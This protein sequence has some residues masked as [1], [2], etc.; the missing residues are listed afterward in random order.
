MRLCLAS[1]ND[2]PMKFF[3]ITNDPEVAAFA[4]TRGVDRIFVDLEMLGKQERQGHLDTVI[5]RHSLADVALVR[6]VVP[7]GGLLV[8]VN[9]IHQHSQAEI[10]AVIDAG[11]DV[12]ML[13]MFR[14]RSE[15]EIFCRAVAGR[16]K[17]SLLVETVAAVESLR[18][19]LRVPG[20]DEVHIGLNDLHL[21]L[22]LRFMFELVAD[23]TVDRMTVV[24][25]GE[26]IPFGIGGLAR[27]GEGLLPAELL[28]AEHARLGSTA[29]I[30]SRTFHRQARSVADIQQQMDFAGEVGKLRSAYA[31]HGKAT[32]AELQ[33][34]HQELQARVSRIVAAM[35]PRLPPMGAVRA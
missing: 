12:V 35:K 16:A 22:G 15:I 21:E 26:G 3:M 30:L 11:A 24:L 13:P 5:S 6:P 1:Q 7:R 19:C 4:V 10:E 2:D 31:I 17:T 34:L 28:L 25:R 20:V 9:P 32:V 23:G 18:E 33:S 8:R 14:G 29:A 27:T